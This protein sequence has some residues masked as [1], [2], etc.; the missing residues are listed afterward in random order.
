MIDC[1]P[2]SL[3]RLAALVTMLLCATGSTP[4][5]APAA[6]RASQ[7]VAWS[8]TANAVLPASGASKAYAAITS[9]A[10]A[11]TASTAPTAPAAAAAP[12]ITA[13]VTK[14]QSATVGSDK[15]P[16]AKPSPCKPLKSGNADDTLLRSALKGVRY[17]NNLVAGSGT[18]P[19]T[20]KLNECALPAGI[21]LLDD[22]RLDGTPSVTG[23]FR[24]SVTVKDSATPPVSVSHDYVLRVYLP[25]TTYTAGTTKAAD[26]KTKPAAQET[27]EGIP[28]DEDERLA[29]ELFPRMTVY[30]LTEAKITA[31]M[32]PPQ[33]DKGGAAGKD[34]KSDG[35]END[36]ENDKESDGGGDTKP[37]AAAKA[38]VGTTPD[39]AYADKLKVIL[40]KLKDAEYPSREL[41]EKALD[42]SL[43]DY[44]RTLA[45]AALAQAN[46]NAKSNSQKLAP[47]KIVCPP[48]RP[49]AASLPPEKLPALEAAKP[50]KIVPPDQVPLTDLPQRI[51]PDALRERI[52]QRAGE[53][54]FFDSPKQRILWTGGN[55]GCVSRRL[56]RQIY[57]FYPFW[58]AA[59]GEPGTPEL[60]PQPIDYSLMTRIAYAAVPIDDTGSLDNI[61]HLDLR[62]PTATNFIHVAKKYRT[63]L[64]VVLYRNT[65][66]DLLADEAKMKRLIEQLPRNA[67]DL[68]DTPLADRVS[69]AQSLLSFVEKTPTVGDGL[70]LYFDDLDDADPI[71]FAAFFEQLMNALIGQMRA[72]QHR[73]YALNVVIPDRLLN[74]A[75]AF[76]FDKLFEYMR[77]AEKLELVL[78]DRIIT[79]VESAES[80]S[81]VDLGY[82]ILL[83]EPTTDSK[84]ALR[85][86]TEDPN[87][88]V[89]KG[90]NRK[91]FLRNLIPVI[92]YVGANPLQFADDLVYFS[93]N[94]NGVGLWDL[95]YNPP[96]PDPGEKIYGQLAENM[97]GQEQGYVDQLCPIVCVNRW[98]GRLALILLALVGTVSIPLRLLLCSGPVQSRRYLF[99]LRIGGVVFALLAAAML[100]CDPELQRL[101]EPLLGPKVLLAAAG[102]LMGLIAWQEK[103]KRYIKP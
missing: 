60:P 102:L 93:D 39:P 90:S 76:M 15:T 17:R 96:A 80:N 68:I 61:M 41:F 57:G 59:G 7:P 10:S 12:T 46:A 13:T 82:L 16:R 94:F 81:N 21:A 2:C 45:T 25:A 88:T 77:S 74:N 23:E 33:A 3:L 91:F 97:L 87:T 52:I 89:L 92:S 1:L 34:G 42:T 101:I 38:V 43:C 100:T 37:A 50:A 53:K 85:L 70:T 51:L 31:L 5:G 84:K 14:S 18:P 28:R 73:N 9:M 65:W 49:P 58:R 55:C 62:G 72:R 40:M 26:N 56:S 69:R 24:F 66:R 32:K 67:L 78:G 75:P 47:A 64:D 95:P 22:G 48:P 54:H 6:T 35:K 36:K 79:N 44:V 19:Y 27:L 20:F 4:A 98:W 86:S 63:K 103:R 29:R 8:S 11:P 71:Q 30:Q 99:F 83:S